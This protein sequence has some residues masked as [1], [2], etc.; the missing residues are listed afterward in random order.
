MLILKSGIKV[1][2]KIIAIMVL[3]SGNFLKA[4]DQLK[5][6]A[7]VSHSE[8]KGIFAGEEEIKLIVIPA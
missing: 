2:L 7:S 1:F 8:G 5:S 3:L 6:L 4:G